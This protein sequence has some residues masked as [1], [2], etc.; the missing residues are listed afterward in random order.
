MDYSIALFLIVVLAVVGLFAW[1]WQKLPTKRLTAITGVTAAGV[2]AFH[3]A[4]LDM[5][6]QLKA[7]FPPEYQPYL[8]VLMFLLTVAARFRKRR[9][10]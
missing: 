1:G 4:F 8:V 3:D 7:A 5:M 6:P 10:T 9:A 2:V